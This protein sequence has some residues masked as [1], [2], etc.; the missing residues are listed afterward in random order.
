MHGFILLISI[1]IFP[2]QPALEKA[3]QLRELE[4]AKAAEKKKIEEAKAEKLRQIE[5]LRQRKDPVVPVGAGA[6]PAPLD[7]TLPKPN[8]SPSLNSSTNLAT[9][10]GFQNIQKK[11]IQNVLNIFQK[12]PETVASTA[13]TQ[14]PVMV[15]PVGSNDFSR[16]PS[17]Q[18][19]P[20]ASTDA[21]T[22]KANT[23]SPVTSSEDAS[24][25]TENVPISNSIRMGPSEPS[26][27]LPMSAEIS[28]E[29]VV[30][31]V[32]SESVV[33]PDE[34]INEPSSAIVASPHVEL[35]KHNISTP[36]VIDC[37]SVPLDSFSAIPPEP[38]VVVPQAV[39]SVV[40]E[41]AEEEYEI[42]SR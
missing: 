21:P 38:K 33:G 24:A 28:A 12:K 39:P 5:E 13:T 35:P 16:M 1:P 9:P 18:E 40:E 15:S 2:F 26:K 6:K 31:S 29:T 4:E 17:A 10:N 41:D 37:V 34:S 36:A 27:V 14:S 7:K 30:K 23:V 22:S 20:V 3:R 19:P 42:A 11:P 25:A 32:I 8:N